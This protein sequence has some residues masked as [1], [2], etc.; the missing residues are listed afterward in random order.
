M[1]WEGWKRVSVKWV[2]GLPGQPPEVLPLPQQIPSRP[3]DLRNAL[4]CPILNI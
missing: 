1:V 3:W 2:Q 4:M